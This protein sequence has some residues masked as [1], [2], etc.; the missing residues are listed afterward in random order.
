MKQI[1]TDDKDYR[2]IMYLYA[3]QK[4]AVKT[5]DGL[6]DWQSIGRGVHQ[7]CVMSPDLFNLYSEIILRRRN[8]INEGILGNDS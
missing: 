4:A 5:K 2:L 8:D 7:G 1:G 6:T 3:K